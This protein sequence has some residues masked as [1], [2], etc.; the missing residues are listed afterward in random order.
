MHT[1]AH[2]NNT[3]ICVIIVK[4]IW[5]SKYSSVTKNLSFFPTLLSTFIFLSRFRNRKKLCWSQDHSLGISILLMLDSQAPWMPRVAQYL[6]KCT[7]NVLFWC[8]CTYTIIPEIKA[9]SLAAVHIAKCDQCCSLVTALVGERGC[10]LFSHGTTL[11][12]S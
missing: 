5:M 6:S 8:Y 9:E 12:W 10:L 1:C 2:L 7:K 3:T 11:I 4:V